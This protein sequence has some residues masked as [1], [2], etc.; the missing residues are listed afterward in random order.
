MCYSCRG[1]CCAARCL[2][3]CSS[4]CCAS[5]S[6]TV[7]W[8]R[9]SVASSSR[10]FCCASRSF[11]SLLSEQCCAAL[12]AGAIPATHAAALRP[13]CKLVLLCVIKKEHSNAQ[14]CS[15]LS[16]SLSLSLSIAKCAV[17]EGGRAPQSP[18]KR[19]ARKSRAVSEHSAKT[20][21]GRRV[22]SRRAYIAASLWSQ[23]A[24]L[25][26]AL[27]QVKVEGASSLF[28]WFVW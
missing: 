11:C 6:K 28:V 15:S 9:A 22:G 26:E 21:N 8:S 4:I 12:S 17:Q 18:L 27:Q 5:R 24:W 23:R 7:A 10:A 3:S 16:L 13:L 19:S 1:I 20:I 14:Q 25:L 2:C